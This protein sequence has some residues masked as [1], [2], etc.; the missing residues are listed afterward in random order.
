[1]IKNLF[2]LFVLI[3]NL[4]YG[5][6]FHRFGRNIEISRVISVIDGDTVE[7][8][9]NTSPDMFFAK[10]FV[11]FWC[12]STWI[13]FIV[14]IGYILMM[15]NDMKIFPFLW[16][17]SIGMASFMNVTSHLKRAIEVEKHL[18]TKIYLALG[19]ADQIQNVYDALELLYER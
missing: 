16:F 7:W 1:M 15:G 13:G 10:L 6:L 19:N 18:K 8:V 4:C 3:I 2:L 9:E 17:F 12:L 14:S 11:C 5:F